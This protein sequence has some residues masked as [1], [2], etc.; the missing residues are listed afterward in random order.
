[1]LKTARHHSLS[2]VCL[3]IL[4]GAYSVLLPQQIKAATGA[5]LSVTKAVESKGSGEYAN[6][7][8]TNIL[9]NTSDPVSGVIVK[10]NVTGLHFEGATYNGSAFSTE[11]KEIYPTDSSVT[12]TRIRTD[13]GFTGQ[14]GLVV[15]LFWQP[16]SLGTATISIDQQNSSAIGY[17]DQRN[18]LTNTT[19][20]EI[21]IS[22]LAPLPVQNVAL[23]AKAPATMKDTSVDEGAMSM[24]MATTSKVSP[25]LQLVRYTLLVIGVLLIGGSILGLRRFYRTPIST[26]Q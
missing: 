21:A 13:K 4:V 3:L 22:T 2:A 26:E 17:N 6:T 1:M 10:I 9:L 25:V 8:S 20:T 19:G 15:T 7:I 11:V 16:I 18:I 24:H 14:N 23:I 12:I 5:S